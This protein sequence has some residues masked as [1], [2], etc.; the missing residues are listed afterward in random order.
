MHVEVQVLDPKLLKGDSNGC[1]LLDAWR[2]PDGNRPFPP[3]P[4]FPVTAQTGKRESTPPAIT[5]WTVFINRNIQ[6]LAS[7]TGSF[8][9]VHDE[10]DIQ[11][12]E[13]LNLSKRPKEVPDSV[14]VKW[15]V[16]VD[17][18]PRSKSGFFPS[19]AP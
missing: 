7:T 9:R 13:W 1:S 5:C 2:Y 11:F 15:G 6:R 16:V 18:L 3:S 14:W 4:T 19:R 12:L 10:L 17:F 8:V